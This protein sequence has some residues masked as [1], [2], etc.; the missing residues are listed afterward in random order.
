MTMF[1][2]PQNYLLNL[3]LD[4][5]VEILS[6]KPDGLETSMFEILDLW[7]DAITGR[8]DSMSEDEFYEIFQWEINAVMVVMSDPP[9]GTAYH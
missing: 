7:D 9:A 8:L 5:A 1:E 6:R 4:E 3:P 2:I